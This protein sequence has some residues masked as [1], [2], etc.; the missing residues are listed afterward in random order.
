MRSLEN[1]FDS[2]RVNDGGDFVPEWDVPDFGKQLIDEL[3]LALKEVAQHPD[4]IGSRRIQIIAG[5][6][7]YGKTH[8]L[9]R[10]R[11]MHEDRVHVAYVAMTSDPDQISPMDHLRWSLVQSLFEN[12]RSFA[13]LRLLFAELLRP[14]FAAFLDQLPDST[15]GIKTLRKELADDPETVLEMLSPVHDLAPYHRLAER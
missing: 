5:G 1:P 7:G 10:V 2:Y 15:T 9:A 4:P 6:S 13:P 3:A 8:H 11:R 14:S 12:S